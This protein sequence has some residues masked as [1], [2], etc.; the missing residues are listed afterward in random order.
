MDHS[1]KAFWTHLK[2]VAAEGPSA[3]ATPRLLVVDDEPPILDFVRRVFEGIDYEIVTAQSGA[4]ALEIAAA[5]EPF[6]G[7]VTDLVMPNMSGDELARRLRAESP[8]LKVLYLTGFSD[9]LFKEKVVLWNDEA[10]LDKPTS[11]DGLRQA[12]ALL[13][14]GTMQ[15]PTTARR[16]TPRTPA[17]V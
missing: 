15:P 9:R 6:D 12:V 10:F 14:Y 3:A 17:T 11:I 13:I 5:S 7:L 2:A 4:E 16:A 1:L 8:D